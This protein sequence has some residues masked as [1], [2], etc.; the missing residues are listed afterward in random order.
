[1][2]DTVDSVIQAV[3]GASKAAALAG[4]RLPAVSNWKA[5]GKIASDKADLF[6]NAVGALGLEI[7]PRV[8]GFKSLSE[9]VRA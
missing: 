4:V 6:R 5:R 7:N 9:E 2:L 3:G 1:M 8:F